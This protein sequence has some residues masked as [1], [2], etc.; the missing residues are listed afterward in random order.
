MGRGSRAKRAK[1]SQA[2][3]WLHALGATLSCMHCNMHFC[4]LLQNSWWRR[5]NDL[6]LN[7]GHFLQLQRK[8][9]AFCDSFVFSSLYKR[10]WCQHVCA[11]AFLSRSTTLTRFP[12]QW[13]KIHL[14]SSSSSSVCGPSS[15]RPPRSASRR[16]H[17]AGPPIPPWSGATC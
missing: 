1:A 10:R 4:N 8:P 12:A 6:T 17:T 7:P 16:R 3:H 5:G 2:F 15:T 13:K 14:P 11:C 9:E